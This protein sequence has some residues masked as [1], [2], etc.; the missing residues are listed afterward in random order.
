MS[1]K[2]LPDLLA[3]GVL[4]Y[5]FVSVARP[6]GN[7]TTRLWLAGWICVEVHFAAY[8]FLDLPGAGG[9]LADIVGTSSLI[10][11]AQLFSWSMDPW[12][13]R[14]GSR[15]LFGA[16]SAVYTLYIVL[17]TLT[18]VP[19]PVMIAAASLFALVPLTVVVATPRKQRP[20]N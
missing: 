5:A 12:A 8:S 14:W 19:P 15:V 17:A 9:V 10:W 2:E 7:M 3:V 16:V 11:C 13:E 4:I 18:A 1:W 6:A 20:V